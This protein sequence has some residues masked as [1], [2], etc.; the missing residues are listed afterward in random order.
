MAGA[1]ANHSNKNPRPL[2]VPQQPAPKPGQRR[3]AKLKWLLIGD[4]ELCGA[5]D[6]RVWRSWGGAGDRL[7]FT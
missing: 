6:R 3:R 2:A 4:G 5:G 7:E 1:N